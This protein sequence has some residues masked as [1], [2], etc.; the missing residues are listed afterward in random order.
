[1]AL[2]LVAPPGVPPDRAAALRAAFQAM[3]TDPAF[4]EDAG[5]IGIE[6]SPIDGDTIVR[7]LERSMATP[8]PVIERYNKLAGDAG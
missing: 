3:V 1:M 2:P 5:K 6:I 4:L 8:K 7:L